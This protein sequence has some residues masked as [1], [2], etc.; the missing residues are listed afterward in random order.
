M[1]RTSQLQLPLIL[2]AQ[3]QKHV[4]VNEALAR[5]DAVAQ[6]RVVSSV[7]AAP[8]TAAGDGTSYLV[9]DGA[10][11][12]WAGMDGRIAVRANGGWV[13]L[14]PRAGWRAWDE[15]RSGTLI[16]D[17]TRWVADAIV[18]SPHGA[19][20]AWQVAEF[21]HAVTEGATN[22][23]L[24]SIPSHSQVIAVSGRVITG[25]SGTGVTGWRIGVSGSDN[26]YG[27]GIGTGAGSSVVGLSGSPLTYYASTPLLL[28]AEGGVFASGTIRL[29]VHLLTIQP[30]RAA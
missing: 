13:F 10:G 27:S 20:T 2:P 5:L 18:V 29:A 30:P 14:S 8:P 26:R 24:V 12:A 16:H 6:L 3:A 22:T 28:T 7:V 21:D 25:L 23:T 4:T 17:G 11:D 1:A 15:S 19:G 9:P